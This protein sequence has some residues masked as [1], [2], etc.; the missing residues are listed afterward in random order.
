MFIVFGSRIDVKLFTSNRC[1]AFQMASPFMI[2]K[3]ST[4]FRRGIPMSN[5]Q[6]IDEDVSIEKHLSKALTK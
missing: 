3:I 5:R 4:E 6:R 2:D 1:H